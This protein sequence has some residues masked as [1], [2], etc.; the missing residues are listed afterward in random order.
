MYFEGSSLKQKNSWRYRVII[1]ILICFALILSGRIIYLTIFN[2]AFLQGQGDM[3]ALRVLEVP[4]NRGM[5][6]DRN[7]SPLA[8]STPVSSIWVDPSN[9][10]F[11]NPHIIE[12]A[13]YLSISSDQLQG[14]I[15]KNQRREFLY[16][17]RGLDP[18]VANKIKKLNIAGLYV[19]LY[20]R[21]FY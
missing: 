15:K 2:R 10:D 17:R 12:L 7:G 1:I 16:L 9:F 20:N 5:I 11:S 8:I 13:Q 6:L 21:R 3:R 18:L 14:H 4:A 19:R